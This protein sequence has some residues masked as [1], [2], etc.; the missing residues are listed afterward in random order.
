MSV[1][2]GGGL[3]SRDGPHGQDLDA[4]LGTGVRAAVVQGVVDGDVAVQGD[5]QQVDH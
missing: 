1:S 4:G 3:T 2:S 5:G